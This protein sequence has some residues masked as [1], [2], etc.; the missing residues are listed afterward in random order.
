[1]GALNLL[2]NCNDLKSLIKA[3]E[4]LTILNNKDTE[5][6]KL[7]RDLKKQIEEQ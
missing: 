6:I 4:I 7:S 2:L 3:I 5:L 1:M